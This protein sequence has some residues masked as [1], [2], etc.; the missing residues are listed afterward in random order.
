MK[1]TMEREAGVGQIAEPTQNPA[2]ATAVADDNNNKTLAPPAAFTG[3]FSGDDLAVNQL[4]IVQASSKTADDFPEGS[5]LLNKNIV[6][7]K[8]GEE[9]TISIIGYDFCYKE[10]F[11]SGKSN[12]PP[13]EKGIVRRKASSREEA[14]LKY[15][16]VCEE[17]PNQTAAPALL[18]KCVMVANEDQQN[19]TCFVH[20]YK[21]DKVA[22]TH[23][24]ADSKTSYRGTKDGSIAGVAQTVMLYHK[25]TGELPF[26]Q[27]NISTQQVKTG[28][29]KTWVPTISVGGKN[30]KEFVAW[31]QST[32]L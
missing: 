8:P 12:T 9:F 24:D 16:L 30:T 15:G 29:V 7:A 17:G 19:N 25:A 21:G 13:D 3:E 26:Q 6:L 14:E 32:L 31:A 20:T 22:S 10:T 11:D 18:M 23:W 1:S 2:T 5:V 28:S 4:S 27:W